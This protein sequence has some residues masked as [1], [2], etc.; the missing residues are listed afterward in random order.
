MKIQEAIDKARLDAIR[1]NYERLSS[2]PEWADLSKMEK[3][4]RLEIE[5]GCSRQTYLPY[6]KEMGIEI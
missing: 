2:M 4:A 1:E 3:Y 6:M 5:C